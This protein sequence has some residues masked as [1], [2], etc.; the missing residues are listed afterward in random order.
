MGALQDEEFF[1]AKTERSE[2]LVA[3]RPLVAEDEVPSL[4]CYTS[5]LPCYT[6]PA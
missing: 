6:S 1:E 3:S 5:P 2:L 4:P